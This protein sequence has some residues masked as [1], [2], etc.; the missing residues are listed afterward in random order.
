MAM[1]PVH[2]VQS[3]RVAA[4]H[5]ALKG[6]EALGGGAGVEWEKSSPCLDPAGLRRGQ[7]KALGK[8]LPKQ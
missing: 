5:P 8:L 2:G 4:A 3:K 7:A 1:D 6:C